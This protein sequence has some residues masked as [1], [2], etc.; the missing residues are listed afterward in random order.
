MA[1]IDAGMATRAERST[2]TQTADD[3]AAKNAKQARAA[4]DAMVQALGGAGVAE[5]EEPGAGRLYR[6]F[7]HGNPDAGTTEYFEF[8]QWPDHDRIELTKHR[9]VVEFYV[10]REGWEVTYQRQ[11]A[12]GQGHSGRLSAAA[13]PLD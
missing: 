2:A 1:A 9:D 7:F 5:H 12:D 8:H 3:E 13:R 11:E 4:L 6:G 10:G